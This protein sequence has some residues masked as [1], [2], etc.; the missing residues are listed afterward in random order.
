MHRNLATE[1]FFASSARYS[2]LTTKPNISLSLVFRKIFI[3]IMVWTY[4]IDQLLQ[5]RDLATDVHVEFEPESSQS[6][7]VSEEVT[8]D[9][10]RFRTNPV[11]Y[12][13]VKFHMDKDVPVSHM[14]HVYNLAQSVQWQHLSSF[15]KKTIGVKAFDIRMMRRSQPTQARIIFESAEEAT[16]FLSKI[17]PDMKLKGRAATFVR[18]TAAPRGSSTINKARKN[19]VD[20]ETSSRIPAALPW[21][22]HK[23]ARKHSDEV[24]GAVVEGTVVDFDDDCCCKATQPALPGGL[25]ASAVVVDDEKMS[26]IQ[27]TKHKP[28]AKKPAQSK[29]GKRRNGG[30]KSVTGICVDHMPRSLDVGMELF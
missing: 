9:V 21:D 12:N 26:T 15:C 4:S 11:G 1:L 16:E 13:E 22:G 28:A 6:E 3:E 25:V 7:E 17:T 24:E 20:I 14:I 30:S 27:G 2:V 18:E 8:E 29:S 10:V 5:M 23:K 19:P